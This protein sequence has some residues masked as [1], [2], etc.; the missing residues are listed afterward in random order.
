M[1]DAG[2]IIL[3][4]PVFFGATT[5]QMASRIETRMKLTTVG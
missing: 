3:A 2:G 4:T 1:I 5:P